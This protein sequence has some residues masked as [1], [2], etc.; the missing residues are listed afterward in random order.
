MLIPIELPDD[1][2]RLLNCQTVAGGV[3][4]KTFI[5]PSLIAQVFAAR[6]LRR[7]LR[8]INARRV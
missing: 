5:N 2:M 6:E 4:V 1:G 8:G 3:E 7:Q